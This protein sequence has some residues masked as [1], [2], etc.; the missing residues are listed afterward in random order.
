VE[1]EGMKIAGKKIFTW[2]NE[3]TKYVV[4]TFVACFLVFG[5]VQCSEGADWNVSGGYNTADGFEI[6]NPN[7]AALEGSILWKSFEF[8]LGYTES[9]YG[10]VVYQVAP[11]LFMVGNT[12]PYLALGGQY[13]AT[14]DYLSSN[15]NFALVGGLYIGDH[16]IAEFKHASNAGLKDPNYGLNW[17]MIGYKL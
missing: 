10:Q 12:Q 4:G 1:E 14:N 13:N 5:M 17:L 15:F 8:S 16:W 7:A 3:I 6:W 2:P 9:A 11:K